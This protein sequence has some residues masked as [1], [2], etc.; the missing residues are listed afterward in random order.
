MKRRGR[1]HGR[2]AVWLKKPAAGTASTS[3]VCPCSFLVSG[4]MSEHEREDE[5]MRMTIT[6]CVP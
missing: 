6:Y 4:P 1:I 3:G 2:L 5:Q